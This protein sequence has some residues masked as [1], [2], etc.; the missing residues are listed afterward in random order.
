MTGTVMVSPHLDDAALSASAK[1]GLGS[2]TVITVFT[3]VP[4]TDWPTSW[5]DM[6][7]GASSS[8][9]RQLERWGEDKAAMQLLNAL[10]IYLD[11]PEFL[12]RSSLPDLSSATQRLAECFS[13]AE[14]VWLP[15][16]I[17]GHPDHLVARDIGLRAAAQAGRSDVMLYAEFP[18][19]FSY[20]WPPCVT[21]QEPRPY[22]DADF[23]LTDQLRQGGIDPESLQPELVVLDAEQRA[24][25]QQ[26]IRA[27]RSQAQALSLSPADLASEPAKLDYELSWRMSADSYSDLPRNPRVGLLSFSVPAPVFTA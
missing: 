4:A 6:L 7:T 24:R 9:E 3:A 2:A 26:I 5:W 21:G 1:L 17:G 13:S 22:V 23:W 25:K 14:E 10:S 11:E 12:Y 27:Y 16:A 18:Y 20:G 19:I 15:A 8:R